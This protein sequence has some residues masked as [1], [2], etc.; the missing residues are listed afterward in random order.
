[1]W[2]ADNTYS[3]VL[4]EFDGN[5]LLILRAL[6]GSGSNYLITELEMKTWTTFDKE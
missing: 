5:L 6:G 2:Y 3:Q 1:M 4:A